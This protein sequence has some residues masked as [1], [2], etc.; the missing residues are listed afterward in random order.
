MVVTFLPNGDVLRNGQLAG[1]NFSSCF[2]VYAD[3]WDASPLAGGNPAGFDWTFHSEDA[4]NLDG[5][6][7]ILVYRGYNTT[8][9]YVP[10]ATHI[11]PWL[12]ADDEVTGELV[13]LGVAPDPGDLKPRFELFVS[14]SLATATLTAPT[15]ELPLMSG[16]RSGS[17]PRA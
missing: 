11:D 15:G 17:A 14:Q 9:M 3:I 4:L 10:G 13:S 7:Q 12:F 1:Q 16:G 6:A 2:G 8:M 5:S